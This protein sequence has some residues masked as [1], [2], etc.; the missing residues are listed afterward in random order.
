MMSDAW[1][2]LSIGDASGGGNDWAPLEWVIRSA[3]GN[4]HDIP[5]PAELETSVAKLTAAGLVE[6]RG[7]EMR[8][9]PLGGEMY[10][11]ANGRG[12]G[13]IQRMFDL[14]KEWEAVG[15]PPPADGDWRLNPADHA[16][17]FARYRAW[18][19]ETYA[20]LKADQARPSTNE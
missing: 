13:H 14:G 16:E 19:D 18:F 12:V 6:V 20:K 8:L 5:S 17:A 10:A 3:D 1:I 15:Y 11:K 4:N 9:T 2:F 7:L